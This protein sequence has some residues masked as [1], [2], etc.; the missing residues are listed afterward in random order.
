MTS[1][2]LDIALKHTTL[3]DLFR[4]MHKSVSARVVFIQ[5]Q[6]QKSIGVQEV[7]PHKLESSDLHLFNH[8]VAFAIAVRH[9]LSAP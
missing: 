9:P 4:C 6:E 5:K 2:I 7:R 3:L 1:S 8:V